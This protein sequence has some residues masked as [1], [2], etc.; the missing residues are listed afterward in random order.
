M[1]LLDKINIY[2]ITVSGGIQ[3]EAN[4]QMKKGEKARARIGIFSVSL[5]TLE[6]RKN[7]V[8]V[9]NSAIVSDFPDFR[10]WWS[11]IIRCR[12]LC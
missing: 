6:T 4:P 9:E 12:R 1:C 8:N 7:A 11:S 3:N 5:N 10:L 2:N